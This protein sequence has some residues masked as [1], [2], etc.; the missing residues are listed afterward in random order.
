MTAAQLDILDVPGPADRERDA[1]LALIA[2]DPKN[3]RS[4]SA[5]VE[6]IAASVD[7]DGC[8]CA[9]LWRPLIPSWVYHRVVGATVN[10]L[11]KAGVLV[12]TGEW[13]VSDDT[14]GRNSGRP[15]RRYRWHGARA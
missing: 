4:R 10:A 5:V 1:V 6:A 7:P 14:H 13:V 8:T 3:A 15:M 9:N 12:P 11:T 2:G